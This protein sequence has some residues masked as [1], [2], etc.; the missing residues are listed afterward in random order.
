MWDMGAS[1]LWLAGGLAGGR[2]RGHKI[3]ARL[4]CNVCSGCYSTPRLPQ[5]LQYISNKK[6]K[7]K[8]PKV[9]TLSLR[10]SLTGDTRRY[11]AVR[12][13]GATALPAIGVVSVF[14]VECGPWGR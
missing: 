3:A 12:S 9:P 10:Y 6:G 8:V 11:T 14:R 13:S 7:K 2:E 5:P 4:N 1:G